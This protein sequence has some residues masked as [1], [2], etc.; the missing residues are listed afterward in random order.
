[1][2]DA[3]NGVRWSSG[4][5]CHR[6][7]DGTGIITQLERVTETAVG[8]EVAAGKPALLEPSHQLRSVGETVERSPISV[9]R[10]VHQR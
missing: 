5:L 9:N 6:C 4:P 1:L 7:Q 3:R 8:I 2:I 10:S